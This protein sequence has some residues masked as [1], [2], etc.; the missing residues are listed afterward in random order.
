M[1][2]VEKSAVKTLPT[3]CQNPPGHQALKKS[4]IYEGRFGQSILTGRFDGDL[5]PVYNDGDQYLSGEIINHFCHFAH[6]LP[7]ECSG[8]ICQGQFLYQ[9]YHFGDARE[10]LCFSRC[11][12]LSRGHRQQNCSPEAEGGKKSSWNPVRPTRVTE[13]WN[14]FNDCSTRKSSYFRTRSR[15]D[16]QLC[17]GMDKCRQA[18]LQGWRPL[19]CHHRL[20]FGN[21]LLAYNCGAKVLGQRS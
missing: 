8:P 20:L 11:L 6:L 19:A 1:I 12:A 16:C 21:L 15:L 3:G 10:S 9:T 4:S 7:K 5:F 13:V 2:H 18:R 14:W 17:Q